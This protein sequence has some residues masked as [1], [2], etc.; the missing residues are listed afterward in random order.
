[1]RAFVEILEEGRRQLQQAALHGG[2]HAELEEPTA[3]PIADIG[4]VQ[5]PVAHE[6]TGDAM[7]AGLRQARALD[8]GGE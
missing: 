2:A 8:E 7:D 6:V 3:E 5:Q 4:P 1:M